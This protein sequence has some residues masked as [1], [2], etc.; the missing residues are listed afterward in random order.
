MSHDISYHL[1]Y[2]INQ[3]TNYI[4]LR[5]IRFITDDIRDSKKFT[6]DKSVLL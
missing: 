2:I 6:D 5:K 1:I 3:S 4:D